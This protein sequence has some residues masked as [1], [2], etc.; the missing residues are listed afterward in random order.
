[1]ISDIHIVTDVLRE[2]AALKP[3]PHRAKEALEAFERI[4]ASCHVD[5][6]QSLIHLAK[7]HVELRMN[8]ND[9][10]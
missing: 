3:S 7:K 2:R 4:L 9:R 10:L 5:E 8:K 1:M 6:G